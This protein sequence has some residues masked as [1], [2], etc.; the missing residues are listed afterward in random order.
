MVAVVTIIL[1]AT[2][3]YREG[4]LKYVHVVHTHIQTH[5][6]S[7]G[8]IKLPNAPVDKYVL[9]MVVLTNC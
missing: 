3:V 4:D 2:G 9:H 1:E 5:T 6:H 7:K 8:F